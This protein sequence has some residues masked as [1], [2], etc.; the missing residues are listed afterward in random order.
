MQRKAG[1]P[2][3]SP[4]RKRSYVLRVCLTPGEFRTL[5]ARAEKFG[6]SVSDIVRAALFKQSID[7]AT[8]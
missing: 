3:K 8:L 4:E 2:F 1:R 5:D 6:L 7:L